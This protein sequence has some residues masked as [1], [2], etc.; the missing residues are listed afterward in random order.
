[1]YSDG[2]PAREDD[3][4]GTPYESKPQLMRRNLDLTRGLVFSGQLLL[5]LAAAGMLR[6][7]AY[8]VVQTHAMKSWET[9][10][11]FRAAIESDEE[12]RK[13]LS[14]EQIKNAFALERQLRN[15]DAIFARV[16]TSKG[17]GVP[18]PLSV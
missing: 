14:L 12:I 7:H 9:G 11:D 15:V 2:L 16:F 17:E 4:A 3:L 18:S 10:G 8:K 13:C 1:M 6:E 5:D